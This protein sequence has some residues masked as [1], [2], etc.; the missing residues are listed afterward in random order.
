MSSSAK[1]CTEA[2]RQLMLSDD[3]VSELSAASNELRL[4]IPSRR[5]LYPRAIEVRT[6]CARG[7]VG[8]R[9]CSKRQ[10][11]SKR[12]HLPALIGGGQGAAH[13]GRVVIHVRRVGGA[14]DDGRHPWIGKEIF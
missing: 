1:L 4:P 2:F 7:L 6:K 10:G 8:C 3:E 9:H 5:W 14:W 13:G 12:H 11:F